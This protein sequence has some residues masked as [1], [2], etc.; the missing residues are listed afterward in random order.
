MSHGRRR[1]FVCPIVPLE[2]VGAF[3]LG[4]AN[5]IEFPFYIR[6]NSA[7]FYALPL[8]FQAPRSLR[9]CLLHSLS[10]E[11]WPER[12]P[13]IER[14]L[15]Q[16]LLSFFRPIRSVFILLLVYG[17]NKQRR[18]SFIYVSGRLQFTIELVVGQVYLYFIT[19]RAP[20]LKL[21]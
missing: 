21:F 8:L 20:S 14:S 2:R 19:L 13:T 7:R 4:L 1:S 12:V 17:A 5:Q 6:S 16:S 10:T 11:F 18:V 9:G 3:L 15:L